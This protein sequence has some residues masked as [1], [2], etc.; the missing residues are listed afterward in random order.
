MLRCLL[1][2]CLQIM[3]ICEATQFQDCPDGW[4]EFSDF[5]YSFVFHP[6]RTQQ[7]AAIACDQGMSLLLRVSS[8]DEHTFI[9]SW[10]TTHDN[11]RSGWLTSGYSDSSGTLIWDSDGTIISKD[12]FLS[13]ESRI[14]DSTDQTMD[15]KVIVY[16]YIG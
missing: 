11:S 14:S 4:F 6:R 3:L 16:K 9:Q 15:S 5:C 2:T 1:V 13:S 10:L 8:A 12:F 7:E